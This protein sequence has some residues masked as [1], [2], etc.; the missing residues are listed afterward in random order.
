MSSNERYVRML[1]RQRQVQITE[2]EKDALRAIPD[3]TPWRDLPPA[4]QA[5]VRRLR[6]IDREERHLKKVLDQ[7]G[8]STYNPQ[9]GKS[10]VNKNTDAVKARVRSA[11][12]AREQRLLSAQNAVLIDVLGGTPKESQTILRKFAATLRA[13]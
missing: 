5:A 11:I 8:F 13:I 3:K 1:V 10:L 12:R 4:V 9:V 6:A 7:R 2:H